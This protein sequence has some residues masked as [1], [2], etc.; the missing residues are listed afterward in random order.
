[1][2]PEHQTR[3][4]RPPRTRYLFDE[5]LPWRVASAL[6]ELEYYTSYVG[7]KEDNAPERGSPDPIV[8]EHARRHNQVLITYNHDMIVLLTEQKQSFIWLDPRGRPFTKEEMVVRI[9]LVAHEWEEILKEASEPVCI[10]TLRTK[11]E[12]LTLD[13]AAHLAKQRMRRLTAR[14]RREPNPRPL[15]PL[16]KTT[17]E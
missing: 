16:I 8:I 15:G 11:N 5:L 6:K 3:R 1:M 7:N 9:F 17:S 13:Y 4:R 2:P 12:V 10:R 14:P